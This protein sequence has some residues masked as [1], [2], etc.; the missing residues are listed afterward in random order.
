MGDSGC[1][2]A[3]SVEAN[4]EKPRCLGRSFDEALES[5]VLGREGFEI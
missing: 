2:F 1:V 4:D 5:I 3:M